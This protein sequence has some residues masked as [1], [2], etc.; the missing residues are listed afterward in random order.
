MISVTFLPNPVVGDQTQYRGAWWGSIV[1]V[2]L[3]FL[4]PLFVN[5]L[6]APLGQV[7]GNQSACGT[8]QTEEEDDQDP[9]GDSSG[10]ILLLRWV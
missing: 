9:D 2:L 7:E 6:S 5:G 4:V 3:I 1:L 10:R 8:S